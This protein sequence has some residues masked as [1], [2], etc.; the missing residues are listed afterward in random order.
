MAWVWANSPAEGIDRLVLL[1]IADQ[2]ADDGGN[3][4]PSVSTI[5]SKAKV[6]ERTVQRSVRRLAERGELVVQETAGKHGV[7]VYRVVMECQP[8]TP[9]DSHPD[10]L[11]PVTESPRQNDGVTGEA[12]G[13]TPVTPRG[14][15]AVTR[16][17]LN[18]PKNHP[19]TKTR[20]EAFAEFWSIYPRRIGKRGAEGE[21]ERALKR[22]DLA[23]ILA[24]AA[25]YRDDPN[26]EDAFTKHPS[27]WLHQDC[28]DDD[29]LPSRT[30]V[31]VPEGRASPPGFGRGSAKAAGWLNLP[32]PTAQGDTP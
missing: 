1:A 22:A 32:D 18:H 11:A 30:R 9:S 24:G 12:Q 6:S 2:A 3:A 5:A 26:R 19:D 17:V 31:A 21:F 28:W 29:P 15:T 14:D 10:T 20:A 27:T 7:N 16:T 4:W 8:V 23:T 13:V 25:R